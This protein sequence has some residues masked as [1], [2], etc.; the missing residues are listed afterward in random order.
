MVEREAARWSA[1]ELR[2]GVEASFERE[3]AETDVLAFAENSGD[4]NPLH[5][6]EAYAATTRQG[7]R[8]A[9][10]AFQVG[11]ASALV[12]MHLP[13]RDCL[14]AAIRAQF[15]SPLSFPVRVRVKGVVTS[16]S[17]TERR[18]NVRVTV[19]RV[20]DAVVTAEVDMAFTL[21]EQAGEKTTAPVPAPQSA[22]QARDQRPIV[23]VTGAAGG[24]GSALCRGL[25]DDYRLLA[26]YRSAPPPAG[27]VGVQADL[28]DPGAMEA[29]E[30]ALGDQPL[31][32]VVHAAWPGLPKGGLLESDPATVAAQVDFG[33]AQTIAL[34]R[35][36]ARRVGEQGRFVAISSTA[37]TRTPV[38]S[39][40]AYSLG[41]ATLEHAVRLLA[42][43]LGR[44]CITANI[45][46]PGFVPV[47][48][49]RAANQRRRKTEAAATPLGRHAENEDVVAAVRR[50]LASDAGFV[51]GES[52]ALTGG[53]L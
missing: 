2:P 47:G 51:S 35:L 1:D 48:M 46:A 52:V 20:D 36:L 18:G 31:Y 30:R 17:A 50:F 53:R 22:F 33:S 27:V 3:V 49:N 7:R 38:L 25:A 24:L 5:V 14:L 19:A 44:K 15:P 41:K 28:S 21:H 40:A 6:D 39:L 9:H 32:G 37:A 4:F 23:L 12:G 45:V 42:P 29:L 16:W 43:E 26:L 11:L 10:G 8:L 13:G 34:A